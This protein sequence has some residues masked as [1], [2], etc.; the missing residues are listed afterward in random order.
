[1]WHWGFE[2]ITIKMSEVKCPL[3]YSFACWLFLLFAPVDFDVCRSVHCSCSPH[4]CFIQTNTCSLY[5]RATYQCPFNFNISPPVTLWRIR[6]SAE[7][8]PLVHC[9][10]PPSHTWLD[11][12]LVLLCLSTHQHLCSLSSSASTFYLHPRMLVS[13]LPS[14][15]NRL[16]PHLHLYAVALVPQEALLAGS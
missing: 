5:E 4:I 12:P 13:S 6:L 3:D 16:L 15:S 8:S 2:S 7:L 1:M 14:L 10:A 11:S 9:Y